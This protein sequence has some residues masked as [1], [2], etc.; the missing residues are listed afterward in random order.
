MKA[1]DTFANP[2]TAVNQL[3]Q[4]DFTYLKV[5]GWGWFYLSTVLDDFSRYIVAWKLCTTMAASD[6][7]ATPCRPQVSIRPR[8]IVGHDSSRTMARPTSRTI[9][10]TGSRNRGF[11]NLASAKSQPDHCRRLG[12][13]AGP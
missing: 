5:I 2:T 1:A 11:H 3:W 10:P 12:F 6:V 8:S 4:T 13:W 9:C 7:T